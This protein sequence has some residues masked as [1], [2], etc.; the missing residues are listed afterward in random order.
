M[1]LSRI[2]L[3]LALPLILCSCF[4]APG[5]F[6][7]S[8][9][10]RKDGSF[11]F[12]YKGEMIFQSPDDVMNEGKGAG[13]TFVESKVTCYK[14]G[15]GEPYYDEYG[16]D[17]VVKQAAESAAAASRAAKGE[18]SGADDAPAADDGIRPCTKA[19]VAK[20]QKV[21][22]DEQATRVAR[23]K[24]QSGEFAAM[25]GFNPAD[26]DANRRLAATMM[27]YDGWKT[28]SYRGKGVFDVEYT[29]A[30]KAGHDF[31][32]PIIP[33]GGDFIIPFVQLRKREGAS[34]IVSAPALV[35]GGMKAL[36]SRAKMMGAA[37]ADKDMPK[38]TIATRGTFTLTTDAEILT[39]NTDDGPV[40][41]ARGRKLVWEIGPET[42]KIPEAL[43]R[44]R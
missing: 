7:S 10:I 41:D 15:G 28:V 35:G 40:A 8:M 34:V 21:F 20:A 43:V 4:L 38:S 36:A 42:E 32:F 24:K 33:Q 39:N 37:M 27:K 12:A 22:D 18:E 17:P 31:V 29:L 19:E 30:S 16:S 26:D 23:D 11:T 2:A 6:T 3:T 5:A 13:R 25:F 1:S 9:D 14:T 44:L